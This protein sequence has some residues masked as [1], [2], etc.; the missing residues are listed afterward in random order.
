[1]NKV[2]RIVISILGVI[3]VLWGLVF[4]IDYVRCSNLMEPVFV[5]AGQT[6][7]DGGSGIY[8]GL[9]YKVKVEKNISAEY[10]PELVKVEMYMF[11]KFITGAIASIHV[12][13]DDTD[14]KYSTITQPQIHNSFVGTVIEETTRYMIVEPNEDEIERKSSDRIVINYG[15]DHIDYL[16]GIGRKVIINYTGYIMETYPAQINTDNILIF[17]YED[18]EIT[19]KESKEKNKTKILNDMDIHKYNSDVNLY[20]YGL[21]EVN[22]KVDNKTMSLEEALRSGKLTLDGLIIKARKD[23]NN[24]LIERKERNDGGTVEFLYKDYTII[25]YHTLDGNRDVYI[26]IPEMRLK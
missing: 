11:D 25:K 6:A 21:E 15:T 2:L 19:V 10:G 5:V 22:V 1:M 16:Y 7:D 4:T 18:F 17:G 12:T 8:Y 3:L 24:K 13:V 9:G 20:Y 23:A 26:G 14:G